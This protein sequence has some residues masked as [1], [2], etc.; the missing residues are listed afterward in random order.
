MLEP[1]EIYRGI[2]I[3]DMRIVDQSS[4]RSRESLRYF[5]VVHG[6]TL[7]DHVSI[8]SLKKKI[9]AAIDDPPDNVS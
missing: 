1:I 9:D 2:E 5:C 3:R 4:D 6:V 7:A 8:E